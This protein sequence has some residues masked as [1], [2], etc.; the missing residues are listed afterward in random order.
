MQINPLTSHIGAEIVDVDLSQPLDDEQFAAIRQAH[1]DWMV[2]VFRDQKLDRAQ[3]KALGKRFGS[4]HV[5]PMNKTRSGD[6]EILVVK[7]TK[8]SVYTAGDGWHTDVTCDEL[9]H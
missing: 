5:H 2:L 9:N 3:H 6:P 7:T 1:L 4:L 8:D